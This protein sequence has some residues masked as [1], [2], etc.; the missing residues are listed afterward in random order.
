MK[1]LAQGGQFTSQENLSDPPLLNLLILPEWLLFSSATREV[2]NNGS[3]HFSD[4]VHDTPAQIAPI[5]A[6]KEVSVRLCVSAAIIFIARSE[7]KP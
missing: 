3:I 4:D 1:S 5:P 2:V 6:W 7:M